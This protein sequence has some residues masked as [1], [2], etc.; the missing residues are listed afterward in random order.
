[1]STSSLRDANPQTLSAGFTTSIWFLAGSLPLLIAVAERLNASDAHTA[2]WIF[3]SYLSCGFSGIGLSLYYRQPIAIGYTIPGLIYI[4]TVAGQFS[5]SE[6]VGANIVAGV[7]I[8]TFGAFGLGSFLL[9]ILPL[10]IVL[11]MFAGGILSYMTRLVTATVEEGLIGGATIF[12]YLLG[13]FL[14]YNRLPPLFLAL[15]FGG[16]ASGLVTDGQIPNANWIA[17]SI[18]IPNATFSITAILTIALPMVILSAGLGTVQGLGFLKSQGYKVKANS[19]TLVVGIGSTISAIFGGVPTIVARSAGA[20]VAGIEAGPPQQRYIGAVVASL[21]LIII[22]LFAMPL[23]S[24]VGLLPKAYV[25]VIAGLAIFSALEDA[26]EK[27]VT[28]DMKSGAL[29]SFCVAATPFSIF[30]ITSS[31]WAIVAGIAMSAV[32]ERRAFKLSDEER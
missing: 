22:G 18:N 2:S 9:R 26:I 15:I 7:I 12:G 11:G 13:R 28:S 25:I 3:V 10:P 23:A 29:V 5:L 30:G 8:V 24:L 20:I 19:I 6:I 31:V 14:A 17:P 16:I 4:G 1:M 32:V 21:S 27:A